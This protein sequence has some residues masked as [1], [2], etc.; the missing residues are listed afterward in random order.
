MVKSMKNINEKNPSSWIDQ[1]L[2]RLQEEELTKQLEALFGVD[3]A[4]RFMNPKLVEK[5]SSKLD[6]PDWNLHK[7]ALQQGAHVLWNNLRSNSRKKL[8]RESKDLNNDYVNHRLINWHA[9]SEHVERFKQR[10]ELMH[11]IAHINEFRTKQ[12]VQS[13]KL[14]SISDDSDSVTSAFTDQMKVIFICFKEEI[15]N[16]S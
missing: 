12:L 3:D 11:K 5:S 6:K 14:P 1:D 8:A 4:D 16:Q 10:V 9:T 2:Q 7:P 15:I 13:V